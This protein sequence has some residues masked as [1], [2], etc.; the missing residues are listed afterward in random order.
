[1]LVTGGAG[2]GKSRLGYEL[3]QRLRR[4]A[5]PPT[6]W[7]GRGDP[8]SAGSAFNLLA[9]ALRG[10]L[11][12]ADGDPLPRAAPASAPAS[13]SSACPSRSASSP[14]GQLL[15]V[16]L[17]EDGVQLRAARRD[18]VLMAIRCAAPSRTSSA[19]Q[20]RR[21]PRPPHSEDLHGDLPTVKFVTRPC[22]ARYRAPARAR[23]RA[24]RGARPL[25][26]ASGRAA[27]STRS[28]CASCRAGPAKPAGARRVLGEATSAETVRRSSSAPTA[29]PSTWRS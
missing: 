12:I 24:P 26:G 16:P 21:G 9:Q 27:A 2:M 22:A 29:T 23:A 4:R 5:D 14:S 13:S 8:I 28:S 20:P 10:A 17:G 15:G 11:G 25:P 3:V 6:L 1:M 19:P 18:P 7:I